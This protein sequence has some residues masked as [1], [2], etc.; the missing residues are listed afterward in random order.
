MRLTKLDH[1]AIRLHTVWLT[2]VEKMSGARRDAGMETLEKLILGAVVLG[3][4]VA[5]GTV[6]KSTSTTLIDRFKAAVGA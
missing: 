5:F 4:A 3:V 2:R 6:F 1:A